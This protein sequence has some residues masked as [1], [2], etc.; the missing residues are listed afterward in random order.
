MGVPAHFTILWT[1]KGGIVWITSFVQ[2]YG[3]ITNLLYKCMVLTNVT[4]VMKREARGIERK[5]TF[6]D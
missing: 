6:R 1:R 4:E 2:F 3:K 5:P